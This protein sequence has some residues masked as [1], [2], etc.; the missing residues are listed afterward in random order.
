MDVITIE[1]KAYRELVSKI[2]KIARFVVENQPVTS[3][4]PDD[5]WVDSYDVRTFLKVSERTLQRLRSN[6]TITYSVMSGKAFYKISEIKR[7]LNEKRIRCNEEFLQDL[8][9]N[10]KLYVEQRRTVKED[11]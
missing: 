2:N 3:S 9:I 4:D 6:G 11:Q 7:M 5:D 10:H 1:S 8:I